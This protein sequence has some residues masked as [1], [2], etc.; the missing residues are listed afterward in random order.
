MLKKVKINKNI[1]YVGMLLFVAVIISTYF[2][3]GIYARYTSKSNSANNGRVASYVF[4]VKEKQGNY[5]IDL[6]NIKKPG[7]VATYEFTV[8]NK[9]ATSVSEVK[10]DYSILIK[11]I[12]TL[13]LTT[14]LIRIND[15]KEVI[16]LNDFISSGSLKE[17]MNPKV[18]ESVTYILEVTW[19]EKYSDYTYAQNGNFSRIEIEINSEQIN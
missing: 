17:S 14:K 4:N 2:V 7:D 15:S 18:E 8:T 16:S 13:P 3:V 9:N 5:F 6:E 11:Q 1:L 10:L 19:D 12:G